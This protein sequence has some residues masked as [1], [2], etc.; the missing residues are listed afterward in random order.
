MGDQLDCRVSAILQTQALYVG[1]ALLCNQPV[2]TLN[3]LASGSSPGMVLSGFILALC[4]SVRD[5][6][7]VELVY[8]QG[9]NHEYVHS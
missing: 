4:T 9:F 3:L 7:L 2:K 5:V 8:L 6:V 1:K